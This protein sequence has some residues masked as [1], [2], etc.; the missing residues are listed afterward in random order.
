MLKQQHSSTKNVQAASHLL[1]P[2]LSPTSQ[3]LK[4]DGG[5]TSPQ[6]SQGGISEIAGGSSYPGSDYLEI[7]VCFRDKQNLRRKVI[8]STSKVAVGTHKLGEPEKVI[9]IQGLLQAGKWTNLCIDLNSLSAHMFQ[10]G[11]KERQQ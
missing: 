9:P 8:L 5:P 3:K 10:P 6:G 1:R 2:S 4:K 11:T 7:E